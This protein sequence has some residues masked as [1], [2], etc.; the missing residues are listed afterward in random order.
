MEADMDQPEV[1]GI[2]VTLMQGHQPLQRDHET[3]ECG[4]VFL[5]VWQI[6]VAGRRPDGA[7]LHR[8]GRFGK[9]APLR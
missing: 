4:N 3:F 8:A 9:P 2:R 5:H 1:Q 7:I 6:H